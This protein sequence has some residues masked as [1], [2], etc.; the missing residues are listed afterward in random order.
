MTIEEL[1]PSTPADQS[2]PPTENR[3]RRT[4]LSRV[5]RLLAF[6]LMGLIILVLIVAGAA[7]LWGV[8]GKLN[9]DRAYSTNAEL[10]RER[11]GDI[12]T[13]DLPD[14]FQPEC[15]VDLRTPILGK[16]LSQWALYQWHDSD[17]FVLVARATRDLTKFKE[18]GKEE[19]NVNAVDLGRI[20]QS[21]LFDRGRIYEPLLFGPPEKLDDVRPDGSLGPPRNRTTPVTEE[22]LEAFLH[23]QRVGVEQLETIE[24]LGK[25][26]KVWFAAG[27]G[28]VNN[29]PYWQVVTAI[30]LEGGSVLLY[31]QV[32][33]SELSRE[34]LEALVRSL[35]APQ[36][37][38]APAAKP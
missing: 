33:Q 38:A 18:I 22:Q 27:T 10:T 26:V 32:K 16:Q 1:S 7:G 29:E 31:A 36:Q 19:R 25:P 15:S 11:L 5:Q 34:Q 37:P 13:I 30:P 17:S 4:L 9:Q 2:Q 21:L 28:A 35:R 23:K 3:A 20:V 6:P 24:L 12:A 14:G 8:I